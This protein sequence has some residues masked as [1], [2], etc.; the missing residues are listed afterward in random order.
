MRAVEVVVTWKAWDE[1]LG[2]SIVK[3]FGLFADTVVTLILKAT[4]DAPQARSFIAYSV[5]SVNASTMISF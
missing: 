3:I 5:L 1:R 4:F 2:R